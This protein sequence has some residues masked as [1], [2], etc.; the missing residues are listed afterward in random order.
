VR[1]AEG[2]QDVVEKN[3]FD[4]LFSDVLD[5]A[6]P[7]TPTQASAQSSDPVTPTQPRPSIQH[8]LDLLDAWS[9]V[10]Q[11][12]NQSEERLWL[13]SQIASHQGCCG[14]L[15]RDRLKGWAKS[16]R[17]QKWDLLSEPDRAHWRVNSDWRQ[18]Q[19]GLSRIGGRK[20]VEEDDPRV[21][22]IIERVKTLV[23]TE[24]T[25]GNDVAFGDILATFRKK[26]EDE[27]RH[28]QNTNAELQK[29]VDDL[30]KSGQ[31]SQE[32]I[33]AITGRFLPELAL[34]GSVGWIVD[35]LEK[36]D[37]IKKGVHARSEQRMCG[38]NDPGLLAH[39]AETEHIKAST[40]CHAML[41]SSYDEMPF[42]FGRM[43]KHVW[44]TAAA[45]ATHQARPSD[46][47]F[48]EKH[49]TFKNCMTFGAVTFPLGKGKVFL[50]AKDQCPGGQAAIKKLNKEFYRDC[51]ALAAGKGTCTVAI[52]NQHVLPKV[53]IPSYQRYRSNC[54]AKC[55]GIRPRRIRR[56]DASAIRGPPARP[57]YRPTGRRCDP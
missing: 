47:A 44:T 13:R 53:V 29:Q 31:Y 28:R 4:E 10:P 35:K 33:N 40:G 37:V 14:K 45:E 43:P 52:F 56:H 7:A 41:Q 26:L 19:L 2:D 21:L 50:H 18:E 25:K 54:S 20:A 23:E 17:E 49:T 8:K 57:H 16:R 39:R 9:T 5:Q 6:S 15:S 34:T 55:R 12:K 3:E 36:F 48:V 42:L 38:L 46:S 24:R 51:F 11:K 30:Y 1:C 32:Q 22:A 27:Q